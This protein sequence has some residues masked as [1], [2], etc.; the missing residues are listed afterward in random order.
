MSFAS[1]SRGLGRFALNNANTVQSLAP[2][3]IGSTALGARTF[4][5]KKKKNLLK[6][7]KG[8]RGRSKNCFRVAIRRVHKSWQYSY[9]D[10]RRK[11]REWHK[12]WI[13]RISAGVRQ[14]SWRYSEFFNHYRK[15]DLQMDRKILAELAANEP[16][17]FRSVLQVVEHQKMSK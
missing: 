15:S 17:A 10:R 8:F 11:K 4:A 7:A 13:Q 14:Y 1:I 2:Y 12:L 9:R 5:S 6:H 3:V 16:F